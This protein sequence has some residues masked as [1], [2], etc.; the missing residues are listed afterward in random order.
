MSYKS[1]NYDC[2]IRDTHRQ[3]TVNVDGWYGYQDVLVYGSLRRGEFNSIG[4]SESCVRF[5]SR[6][7]GWTLTM[8]IPGMDSIRILVQVEKVEDNEY[9][10]LTPELWRWRSLP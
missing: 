5:V 9:G 8:Y 1:T 6:E 10:A 2:E 7:D 4:G 3:T